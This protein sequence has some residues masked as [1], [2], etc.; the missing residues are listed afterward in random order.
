MARNGDW[1]SIYHNKLDTDL[2]LSQ[3]RQFTFKI[4]ILHTSASGKNVS[5]SY[6]SYNWGATSPLCS[7]IS[8][9][10]SKKWKKSPQKSPY[11]WHC[12]ACE[13][14]DLNILMKHLCGKW[15][16]CDTWS[17]IKSLLITCYWAGFSGINVA[18]SRCYEH[19]NIT[20]VTRCYTL[21]RTSQHNTRETPRHASHINTHN[22][23]YEKMCGIARKILGVSRGWANML[24]GSCLSVNTTPSC[25][26]ALNTIKCT[27]EGRG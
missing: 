5:L 16:E 18:R 23:F 19:L 11:N 27:E 12:H 4:I 3:A 24:G 6:S 8:L 14:E 2:I 21:L 15:G 10:Y 22:T 17:R 20:Q 26:N 9:T 7:A 25:Y 1:A 13:N